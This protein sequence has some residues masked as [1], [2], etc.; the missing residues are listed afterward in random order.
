[1]ANVVLVIRTW[2]KMY[3]HSSVSIYWNGELVGKIEPFCQPASNAEY[4][5]FNKLAELGYVPNLPEHT[6]PWRYFRENEIKYATEVIQVARKKD[7]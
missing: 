1:M 7:L 3:T 5:A 4:T 6:P 2:F